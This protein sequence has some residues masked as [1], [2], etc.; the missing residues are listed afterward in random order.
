M[1]RDSEITYR[2]IPIV[3]VDLT[4]GVLSLQGCV[5][6]PCYLMQLVQSVINII[7]FLLLLKLFI[8]R[9]TTI[10]LGGIK[11]DVKIMS[12]QT[13]FKT[14]LLLVADRAVFVKF[15]QGGLTLW[16]KPKAGSR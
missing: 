4:P 16:G 1:L 6:T 10:K 5:Y 7:I 3:L 11:A 8:A 9:S 13:A 12:I 2:P 15:Q 14:V